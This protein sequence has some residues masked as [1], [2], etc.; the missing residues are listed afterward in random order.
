MAD[1]RANAYWEGGRAVIRASAL[2]SAC[3]QSLARSLAGMPAEAPPASM[4]ARF[5]EGSAAEAVILERLANEYGWKGV[6]EDLLGLYGTIGDDGQVETELK[7]AGHVVRCH[8]DDVAVRLDT[9]SPEGEPDW[10][11]VGTLAAVEVKALGEDLFRRF[12]REG[13]NIIP[14]Y[15]WQASVEMLTTG[16]PLVYVAAMKN[17]EGLVDGDSPLELRYYD[18]PLIS[19]ATIARRVLEVVRMARVMDEGGSAE[20]CEA[21][22]YPCGYYYLPDTACGKKTER[23]ESDDAE[24]KEAARAYYWANV[25]KDKAEKR[26]LEA[27][28][29]LLKLLSESTQAGGYTVDY[30]PSGEGRIN[31]AN[32]AD[33]MKVLVDDDQWTELVD[34]HRGKPTAASVTVKKI[35]KTEET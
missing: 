6:G 5:A 21:A 7:I 20:A 35:D 15:P 8:P 32:V 2:G 30:K 24:V 28:D 16:L 34:K 23:A 18:S 27:R 11:K 10:V 29:V 14:T 13:C 12:I 9:Q 31:W 1:Q 26:R 25:D 4:L 17:A 22:Q 33:E 3:P 19:F